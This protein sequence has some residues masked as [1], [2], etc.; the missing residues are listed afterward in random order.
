MRYEYGGLPA[1]VTHDGVNLDR[2]F[3]RIKILLRVLSRANY[4][5]RA[6]VGPE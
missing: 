3:V 4:M 6:H 2:K 1:V 5:V